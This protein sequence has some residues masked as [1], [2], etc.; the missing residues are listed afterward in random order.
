VIGAQQQP[1]E[2]ERR[3]ERA[4]DEATAGRGREL[5]SGKT[6]AGRCQTARQ[7]RARGRAT[8]MTS[9]SG[10]KLLRD[11]EATGSL[12]QRGNAK[13]RWERADGMTAAGRRRRA[14]AERR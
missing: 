12:Q 7:G 4:V 8:S 14:F 10:Q 13:R 11:A 5:V 9:A 6:M 1:R 2:V 3:Q